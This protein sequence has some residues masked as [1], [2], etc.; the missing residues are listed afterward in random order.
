VLE[1]ELVGWDSGIGAL[2]GVGLGPV[3]LGN[4]LAAAGAPL[5]FGLDLY[6]N[7]ALPNPREKYCG[8][9]TNLML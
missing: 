3:G 5:S 8:H 7:L 6:G 1:G 9:R 2:S 4:P